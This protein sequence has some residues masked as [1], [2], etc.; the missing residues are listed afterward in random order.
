M[1][2]H[3]FSIVFYDK[4]DGTKPAK[5]FI[6][7]LPPKMQAKVLRIINM[8][9]VNGTDLREPYSK[10]LNE[11]IFEL[12]AQLGSDITRVLYFFVIGRKAVLTHGF[13][14]KTQKTPP[15]EIEK[16][17]MYRAEYLSRKEK[18]ENE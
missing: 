16:A 12:R 2:K 15:F 10:Y 6:T 3:G 1:A 9:E 8:L 11:G 17:R 7:G 14:K 5:E 13:V 4:T 18:D